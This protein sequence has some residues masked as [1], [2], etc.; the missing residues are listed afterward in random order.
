MFFVPLSVFSQQADLIL[1]GATIITLA[2]QGDR[3]TD[4]AI[5]GNKIIA[6]G[7]TR[8]VAPYKGVKTRVIELKGKLLSRVL[9]TSTSIQNLYTLPRP[10]IRC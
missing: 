1:S 6:V 9:M 5:K 4:L 10:C 7:S 2:K 8:S 3:A